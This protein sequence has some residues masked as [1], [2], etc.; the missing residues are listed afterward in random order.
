MK[1]SYKDVPICHWNKPK[2]AALVG[3]MAGSSSCRGWSGWVSV[4][5][6]PWEPVDGLMAVSSGTAQ[7]APTSFLPRHQ[8]NRCSGAFRQGNAFRLFKCFRK[9]VTLMSVGKIDYCSF[10][11]ATNFGLWWRCFPPPLNGFI[12]FLSKWI[13]QWHFLLHWA[14]FAEDKI[15]AS[16]TLC[17]HKDLLHR[18]RFLHMQFK[19]PLS[20][21]GEANSSSSQ[22]SSVPALAAEQGK[23][24]YRHLS[25]YI[26]TLLGL[27]TWQGGICLWEEF[28]QVLECFVQQQWVAECAINLGNAISIPASHKKNYQNNI[29]VFFQMLNY[30]SF[31]ETGTWGKVGRGLGRKHYIPHDLGSICDKLI[32][33]PSLKEAI[34][35]YIWP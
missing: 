4:A 29:L 19:S 26:K 12:C 28:L 23:N 15:C 21:C 31:W 16:A 10:T 7:V 18:L 14:R 22:C 34:Y 25:N 2:Q 17:E 9:T 24:L 33:I 35:V 30:L 5:S 3:L 27:V 11:H 1:C 32:N 8:L 6:C 20:M 13:S